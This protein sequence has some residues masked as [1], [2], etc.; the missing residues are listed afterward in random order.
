M[1]TE[2]K[3]DYFIKIKDNYIKNDLVP[4]LNEFK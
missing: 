1:I 2:E 4:K 3:S